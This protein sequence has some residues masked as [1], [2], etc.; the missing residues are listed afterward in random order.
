MS[1]ALAQMKLNNKHGLR[2]KTFRFV[3]LDSFVLTTD[4]H[5]HGLLVHLMVTTTTILVIAT[6]LPMILALV[7]QV[8]AAQVQ[9]QAALLQLDQAITH[10]ALVALDQAIIHQALEL[11]DHVTALVVNFKSHRPR[12]IWGL[13]FILK[14]I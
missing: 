10:Q 8:Q 12:L 7:A 11:V 13:F 5:L 9:V 3:K 2:L 1:L 6:D 14:L 4:L